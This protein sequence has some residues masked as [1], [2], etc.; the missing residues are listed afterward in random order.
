M[1]LHVEV[2]GRG[3]DIAL[4][5]GWAL[6]G[7]M[8]GPWL[9]ELSLH[10]RLHIV[11]LPG[12]GYSAWHEGIEDLPGLARAVRPCLPPDAALLGWSLGGMIALELAH[13]DPRQISALVLVATTPRFVAGSDWAH[14]MPPPVFDEFANGL[15]SNHRSAVQNFLALQT[16]GDV[17]SL[18]TLRLLRRKLDA[19]GPPDVR[20][21]RAGLE[22]LRTADL[23]SALT[24]ITVPALVIAGSHDRLARPSAARTMAEALPRA[25]YR[26]I[27][28]SG[29]A[30]FFSH[31]AEVLREVVEFLGLGLAPAGCGAST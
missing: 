26:E 3:R 5:H 21:L 19:H 11:D 20:A 1:N 30:P 12:Q 17:R 14:G 28:H 2:R 10:A 13:Q 6:H 23:R 29:H 27:A 4:L 24:A 31:G 22:I 18:E 8:W 16:R 25:R 7:G 9:D 15:A